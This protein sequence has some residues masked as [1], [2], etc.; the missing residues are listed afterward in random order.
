MKKCSPRAGGP[1][2]AS[3]SQRKSHMGNMYKDV[4]C[5]VVGGDEELE[6]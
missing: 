5:G 4:H 3:I 1:T 2:D 6:A